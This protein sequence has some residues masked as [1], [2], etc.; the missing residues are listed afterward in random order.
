MPLRKI[1][2]APYAEQDI[3]SVLISSPATVSR[4]R[5]IMHR[6]KFEK[7]KDDLLGEAVLLILKDK[8]P[9]NFK[10][11]AVKLKIM[12]STERDFERRSTLSAAVIEV[13][14]KV[15]SRGGE[16]SGAIINCNINRMHSPVVNNTQHKYDKKH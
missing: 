7:L 4:A 10:S 6:T 16:H 1:G 3:D 8:G 5:T 15:R 9:I 14:Q 2:R 13:E 11:L 12:A